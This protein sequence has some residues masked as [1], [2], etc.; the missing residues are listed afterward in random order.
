MQSPLD[1]WLEHAV[2][3]EHGALPQHTQI[4][5]TV[6]QDRIGPENAAQQFIDNTSSSR[7]DQDT[8]YRLWNLLFHTAANLPYHI[9]A[10]VYLTLAIY[11]VPPS[12]Q[13]S[14][15]FTYNLWTNWQD[16]YSYYHTSRTLASPASADTLTNANRWI[17]FTVFSATLLNQSDNEIFVTEIGIHA[18]F[19]LRNAL[20]RTLETHAGKTLRQ[21]SVVTAEQAM[22]TDVV[23]AAQ[24]VLDAGDQL[25]GHDN[26]GF[27]EKWRRGLS[28]ETELWDGEMG[29]SRR[30]REVWAQRFEEIAKEEWMSEEGR[31]VAEEAGEAIRGYLSQQSG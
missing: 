9:N 25:L 20:E 2:A 14:N 31:K 18:F 21:N 5:Q 4:L 17:N 30:R 11:N 1:Q 29:F 27:G 19:D 15:A 8:A 3:Q 12:P 16:V 23:A 26:A 10:I 13:V 28:K 24:W 6:I 7:D 22:E